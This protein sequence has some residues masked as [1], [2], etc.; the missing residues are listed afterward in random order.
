MKFRMRSCG[1]SATS[2][3]TSSLEMASMFGRMYVE[4]ISAKMCTETRTVVHT[5][6]IINSHSGTFVGSF[7][8]SST[9]ATMA[10]P[11]NSSLVVEVAF[12]LARDICNR[13]HDKPSGVGFGGPFNSFT[14]PIS[15]K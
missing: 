7:I 10:K 1:L 14:Q 11:D 13:R 6:N 15:S 9:I 4:I 3:H 8:C 2:S 12:S 5:A